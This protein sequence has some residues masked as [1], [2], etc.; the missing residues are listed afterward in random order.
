M[1]ALD[2]ANPKNSSNV[3]K[4]FNLLRERELFLDKFFEVIKIREKESILGKVPPGKVF[5]LVDLPSEIELLDIREELDR[6]NILNSSFSASNIPKMLKKNQAAIFN[7]E[8]NKH[9]ISCL[10]T[11]VEY[12]CVINTI[13]KKINNI[14][15]KLKDAIEK[16]KLAGLSNEYKI[17]SKYKFPEN[18]HTSLKNY[19]E[20]FFVPTNKDWNISI[21][22]LWQALNVEAALIVAPSIRSLSFNNIDNNSNSVYN[23]VGI[24]NPNY[25][26]SE[27]I[28]N[29]IPE[30]IEGIRFRSIDIRSKLTQFSQLPSTEGEIVLSA[31]NFNEPKKI[32]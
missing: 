6:E 16:K 3:V 8:K 11:Y 25:S 29:N 7:I 4:Y 30:G 9:Q 24:G 23:Y 15:S 2:R 32:F 31:A 18:I 1:E 5:P 19:K 26:S 20:V 21:N 13:P 17:L 22:L 12:N 27:I 28:A 14:Y 10:V